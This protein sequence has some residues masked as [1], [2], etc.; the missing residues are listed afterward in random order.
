MKIPKELRYKIAIQRTKIVIIDPNK[1]RVHYTIEM[2]FDTTIFDI[3]ETK[4]K[5]GLKEYSSILLLR[6]FTIGRILASIKKVLPEKIKILT[7]NRMT[8]SKLIKLDCILLPLGTSE[9][10]SEFIQKKKG[11]KKLQIKDHFE[12]SKVESFF[13]TPQE[14][15]RSNQY[16]RVFVFRKKRNRI[17]PFGLILGTYKGNSE[18]FFLSNKSINSFKSYFDSIFKDIIERE[19][20]RQNQSK[21]KIQLNEKLNSR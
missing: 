4:D 21:L 16:S 6:H 8:I 5:V 17:Y 12:S 9:L 13:L 3:H 10:E 18:F 1:D 7:R 20:S 2:G 19:I 15:R 11:G 14:F